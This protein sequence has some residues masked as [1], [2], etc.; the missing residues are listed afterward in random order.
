MRDA[1]GCRVDRGIHSRTAFAQPEAGSH[2]T[3]TGQSQRI[4]LPRDVVAIR[5]HEALIQDPPRNPK[6]RKG[7]LWWS[8]KMAESELLFPAR[9]GGLRARSCLAKPMQDI[10]RE[11][12][13]TFDVTP[14]MVR[15]TFKDLARMAGMSDLAS[16]AISGH[17]TDAMHAHY[18]TLSGDEQRAELSK[19]VTLLE[20]GEK[21]AG[22][23]LWGLNWGVKAP[24]VANASR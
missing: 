13:L 18:Q 23:K 17:K 7:R 6:T 2:K 1:C 10:S 4:A 8:E 22:L 5:E 24:A 3:K 16:K 20:R 9:S 19:V 12:G 11:I 21:R 15:R 14:R